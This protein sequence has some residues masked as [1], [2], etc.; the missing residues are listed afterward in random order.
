MTITG[1]CQPENAS[2]IKF[3]SGKLN[4]LSGQSIKAQVTTEACNINAYCITI[5]KIPSCRNET[6]EKVSR[7]PIY[8]CIIIP[9]HSKFKHEKKWD[10]ANSP[11]SLITSIYNIVKP[12]VQDPC[13]VQRSANNI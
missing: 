8:K 3:P 7:Q 6:Q 12:L 2:Q 1:L 4:G 10:D 13:G 11:F 9:L 5:P